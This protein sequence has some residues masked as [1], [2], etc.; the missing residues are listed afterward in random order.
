MFVAPLGKLFHS[1]THTHQHTQP[2]RTDVVKIK[3]QTQI[4]TDPSRPYRTMIQSLYEIARHE[5]FLGAWRGNTAAEILYVSFT[6]FQFGTYHTLKRVILED[7]EMTKIPSHLSFICGAAAGTT[8]CLLTYPFDLI[9]T[10]MA[11]R[12][13]ESLS[14][15]V[16]LRDTIQ[17]KGTSGLFWGLKPSLLQTAVYMGTSFAIYEFTLDRVSSIWDRNNNNKTDSTIPMTVAGAIAGMISKFV[18]FPID[19]VKKRMQTFQLDRHLLRPSQR[20]EI[21]HMRG[22]IHC[23]RTMMM[24]EGALSFYSG[25][26]TAVVKS[27]VT[28]AIAYPLYSH[29]RRMI[30]RKLNNVDDDHQR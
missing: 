1:H 26:G 9:R 24:K 2:T 6:A 19:T 20:M 5:G 4:K 13:V 7:S 18:A 29:F 17:T 3:L 25:V 15:S 12:G 10:Q 8:A 14:L 30:G 22:A 16:I 23:A 11:V 27:A 28:A 21:Q